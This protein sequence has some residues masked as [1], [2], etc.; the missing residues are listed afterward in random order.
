MSFYFVQLI[1]INSCKDES[2]LWV[3]LHPLTLKK[4]LVICLFALTSSC[5]CQASYQA[6]YITQGDLGFL[7]GQTEIKIEFDYED[8]TI[9]NGVPEKEFKTRKIEYLNKKGAG[10]GD[11]WER[12]WN[13]YRM[14]Y[15]EPNFKKAFEDHSRLALSNDTC[16]YKLIFKTLRFYDEALLTPPDEEAEPVKKP[17]Y[18]DAQA[19]IIERENPDNILVQIVMQNIPGNLSGNYRSFYSGSTATALIYDVRVRLSL[20]YTEAGK[21]LGAFIANKISKRK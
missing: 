16:R 3:L 4:L 9:A 13:Q 21:S 7:K 6:M 8:V 11:K 20:V 2:L 10:R 12:S 14:D 17:A 5:Y 1:K 15:F 18:A 19:W